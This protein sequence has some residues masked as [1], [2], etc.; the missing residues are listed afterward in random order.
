MWS[1]L[2]NRYLLRGMKPRVVKQEKQA[3]RKSGEGLPMRLS[4]CFV[5]SHK[6]SLFHP[7]LSFYF[8]FSFSILPSMHIERDGEKEIHIHTHTRIQTLIHIHWEGEGMET[9]G[10]ST[11]YLNA[12]LGSDKR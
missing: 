9:E 7:C 1:Q 8:L 11:F 5:F 12:Q 10:K 4:I 2:C 6:K 3:E